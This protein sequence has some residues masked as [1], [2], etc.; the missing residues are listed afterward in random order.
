M[1]FTGFTDDKEFSASSSYK[2]IK[3]NEHSITWE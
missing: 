3:F 1:W 2:F